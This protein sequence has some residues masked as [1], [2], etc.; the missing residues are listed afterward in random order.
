[1]SAWRA[2]FCVPRRDPVTCPWV[3][4]QLV[5]GMGELSTASKQVGVAYA[6]HIGSAPAGILVG[7]VWMDRACVIA[8]HQS[9]LGRARS[10]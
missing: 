5:L 7:L 1:V 6:T 8:D 4:L 3:V 2:F 9:D 10:R